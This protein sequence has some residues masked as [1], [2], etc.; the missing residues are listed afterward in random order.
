MYLDTRELYRRQCELA[1]E[2]DA[3][4]D[5]V[6]AAQEALDE[7]EDEDDQEDL[8][9]D[10]NV[11]TAALEDWEEEYRDELTK[12]NDLEREVGDNWMHGETLIPEDDF[13][14]YAEE[15]AADLYGNE[16]RDADWP[17]DCIDWERAA[18]ALRMDYSSVEYQGTTYLFRS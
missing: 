15:L 14:D 9:D 12:L 16:I 4:K 18:D 11:A 7:C 17:F 5:D 2:V 3:L 6:A 1:E 8:A 10:L 13:E